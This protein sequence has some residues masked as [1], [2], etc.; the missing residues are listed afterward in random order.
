MK[1]RQLNEIAFYTFALLRPFDPAPW[2]CHITHHAG[3]C[4][5]HVVVG[6]G[7]TYHEAWRDAVR[8]EENF[9]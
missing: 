4:K 6:V 5:G 2:R 9:K 8:L 7:R 1:R 3:P